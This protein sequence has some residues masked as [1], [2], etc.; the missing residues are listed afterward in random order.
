MDRSVEKIN[1]IM[2]KENIDFEEFPLLDGFKFIPYNP[3][4]QEKWVHIQ[5]KSK[6]ILEKEEGEKYFKEIFLKKEDCLK[7]RMVFIENKKGDLV[8]T[9]AIWEGG[10]FSNIKDIKYR[11]HWIAIDSEYSGMGLGKALVSKLLNVFK[12]QN[13]GNKIY[14]STQT[15]SYVAIKIYFKFGFLAY[16][17]IENQKGWDIVNTKI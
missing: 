14:I 2:L 16:D 12:K 10:Y 9:G 3:E 4:L 17:D 8:G 11:L 7:E 13:L 1:L 15:C 5:L 6:H